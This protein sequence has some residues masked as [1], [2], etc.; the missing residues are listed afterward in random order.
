M[1]I[2]ARASFLLGLTDHGVVCVCDCTITEG[3]TPDAGEPDSS[4][5][6]RGFRISTQVAF[7]GG[8]GAVSCVKRGRT[9]LDAS[10][11]IA[12]QVQVMVLG[13]PALS[14]S[15]ASQADETAQ[16]RSSRATAAAMFEQLYAYVRHN[17]TPLV[18]SYASQTVGGGQGDT[19]AAAALAEVRKHLSQLELSLANFRQ[20]VEIPEVHLKVPAEITAALAKAEELGLTVNEDIDLDALGLADVVADQG[21]AARL[22]AALSSWIDDVAVVSRLDRDA[23]SGTTADEIKF[24][25]RLSS[26][27]T[28]LNQIKSGPEVGEWL[29]AA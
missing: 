13:S 4:F 7:Q 11:S 27:L 17:F 6:Q 1:L 24:W 26:A 12:T 25:T 10:K 14:S 15:A 3:S 21:F 18:R 9:T 28:D 23:S 2:G 5:T 16:P 22:R 20:D 29:H 8:S 19:D